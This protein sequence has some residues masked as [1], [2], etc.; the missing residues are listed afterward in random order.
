MQK[1]AL[2]GLLIIGVL[3][4]AVE[5]AAAQRQ[6]EMLD[7]GLAAIVREEGG[8]YLGWRLLQEDPKTVGFD[9]Y[10][11]TGDADELKLNDKRSE[12]RR[13]GKLCR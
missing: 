6:A 1:Q 11:K 2:F 7:R 4:I 10:R 8:V 3:N 5:T 13:G 9:L 12:E